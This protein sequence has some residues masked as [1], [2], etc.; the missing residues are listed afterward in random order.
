[1][2]EQIESLQVCVCAVRSKCK[3]QSHPA[4]LSQRLRVF[5]CRGGTAGI[6][7]S[8]LIAAFNTPLSQRGGLRA[9]PGPHYS[10]L[11]Q[12]EG[13]SVERKDREMNPLELV[14]I[15]RQRFRA[16]ELL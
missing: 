7:Q 8:C 2:C 5:P 10:L 9:G 6:D 14:N 15:N 1:M 11:R 3:I 16:S 4:R 13:G 12:A